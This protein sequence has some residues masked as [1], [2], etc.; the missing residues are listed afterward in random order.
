M[1][2][3]LC[4]RA[5]A[6]WTDIRDNL[7]D[8]P[9]H[10]IPARRLRVESLESRRMLATIVPQQSSG[11]I[12]GDVDVLWIRGNVFDKSLST[13]TS[14][15][16]ANR[17]AMDD[18]YRRNS[19]GTTFVDAFDI[20][21]IYDIDANV[22]N[23]GQLASA[24]R[25]AAQSD[26]FNLSDYSRFAYHFP[27]P[28]SSVPFPG[29][30][31]GSGNGGSGQM[32]IPDGVLSFIPGVVHESIHTFGLGHAEHIE[33]GTSIFPG[34][35]SGGLD[36][37]YFM[38][39]EGPAQLDADLP[40]YMKYY[41]G[42]LRA[43]NVTVAPDDP[44]GVYRIYNAENPALD[45]NR[46]VA[47]QIGTAGD[48]PVWLSYAPDSPNDFL[49]TRGVLAH[50]LPPQ[51]PA[52]TR[53]LD[54]TPEV[55]PAEAP[56]S[57]VG[58]YILD[59]LWDAA[60]VVGQTSS[61]FDFQFTPIATGGSGVDAWVDIEVK[62]ADVVSVDLS[63][64]EYHYDFGT[65]TSP[66]TPGFTRVTPITAG[67]IRW[68]SDVVAIDRASGSSSDRDF[69]TSTQTTV[70][71]HK[72][73]NGLWRV[74]MKM[75]D[76]TLARDDMGLRVEGMLIT[77]D[78][79][80]PAG[81]VSYVDSS[82]ASA[83]EVSFDVSVSDGS[84]TFEFSDQGGSDPAWTLNE[85]SLELQGVAV[86]LSRAS[87]D[88]DL[89][90][91]GSPVSTGFQAITPETQGDI[92]WSDTV[93]AIDRGSFAATPTT[94]DFI[95][96]NETRTLEH[97]VEN[98]LWRVTLQM[99]DNFQAHD[100][101]SVRAEGQLIAGGFDSAAARFPYISTAGASLT[102]ATFE[103]AVTDG[104]LSL[105]FS[106]ADGTSSGDNGWVATRLSL[107]RAGGAIDLSQREFRY[108][109]GHSYSPV[110]P[111]WTQ[112]SPL[113]ITGDVRWTSPVDSRDRYSAATTNLPHPVNRDFI[114]TS[115]ASTLEHKVANG[116]WRVT[117][118]MG[119]RLNAHDNMRV[120]AEGQIISSD[121]D[122]AINQIVYVSTA[123]ESLTPASFI[124][125]V[126]DG[127]LSLTFDDLG[128]DANW[129]VNSMIL[130]RVDVPGDFNNDGD[131]NN[132]D[133]NQWQG[134]Y[135][136]NGDS[137]ADDDGN[138]DG[139]DFLTWQQNF[140]PSQAN[141]STVSAAQATIPTAVVTTP[142][143]YE[144]QFY[145]N[146]N[147]DDG[148]GCPCGGLGC[149]ACLPSVSPASLPTVANESLAFVS[150][151][152]ALEFGELAGVSLQSLRKVA[153]GQD[154]N[155]R[156]VSVDRFFSNYDLQRFD[157]A[158]VNNVVM[159]VEGSDTKERRIPQDS[160]EANQDFEVQKHVNL[161]GL[162]RSFSG[163]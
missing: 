31:L 8:Y 147:L 7:S 78:I 11:L 160:D 39:S 113:N 20:T 48:E 18:Y 136:I 24:L 96:A 61:V 75:G 1:L 52:V 109:F 30:A 141:I 54:L 33:G 108:D 2:N 38:G 17:D 158:P 159:P 102:E 98:G 139:F 72:I 146:E 53:L 151:Q 55:T 40:V 91:A 69:V 9:L 127:S 117:L 15:I 36:P 134:D 152:P 124:V 131:V 110:E 162:F 12:Q 112:I 50:Y 5:R 89:G 122:A 87:Y 86:D 76:R 97:R 101:M 163:Q 105:E 130:E 153:T 106:D 37:Y 25:S 125:D 34:S 56:S 70:L 84:L 115:T 93:T 58:R 111:G 100:N 128:G 104:Y 41:I 138:S 35:V 32:W 161:D 64:T 90:P 14:E 118:T 148:G 46:K 107:E 47:L 154:V 60:A 29:G 62:R 49:E 42:W 143:T 140:A 6:I 63:E 126:Q 144:K 43:S 80:S 77:S 79:D 82:G 145:P 133:L 67:D 94:R 142:P 3:G 135:G 19:A 68:N 10:S 150:R 95:T 16:I 26:G 119:D 28:P 156:E 114:H 74:T 83:T 44:T 57:E 132:L 51:S 85:M 71:E 149:A 66:V 27:N 92:F 23:I 88:Y 121:I 13:G 123:G 4:K 22:S 59:D 155:P 99:G 65:E 120:R 137:D 81:Q 116:Q 103:I 45:A 73:A 21:P 129:V 157:S